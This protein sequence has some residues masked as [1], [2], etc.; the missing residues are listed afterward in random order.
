MTTTN[1]LSTH[2]TIRQP[3]NQRQLAA[4]FRT[5]AE[6][7]RSLVK[8]WNKTL[9][10]CFWHTVRELRPY[11]SPLALLFNCVVYCCVLFELNLHYKSNSDK[12]LQNKPQKEQKTHLWPHSPWRTQILHTWSWGLLHRGSTGHGL[13]LAGRSPARR[14]GM[15]GT[16]HQKSDQLDTDLRGW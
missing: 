10:K 15:G 2:L 8:S 16:H 9:I 14:A 1:N 11:W 6:A 12:Y 4:G 13:V 5:V 3:S 7:K